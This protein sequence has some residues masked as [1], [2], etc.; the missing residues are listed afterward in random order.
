M[1]DEFAGQ[2][3]T[4][5]LDPE[6]GKRTLVRQTAP[7]GSEAKPLQAQEPAPPPVNA[8]PPH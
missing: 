4:Y 1:N 7:R 8:E 3:G 5:I 6:T 2:G